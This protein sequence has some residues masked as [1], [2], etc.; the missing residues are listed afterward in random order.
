SCVHHHLPLCLM[1]LSRRCWCT[2]TS[3]SSCRHIISGLQKEL[4]TVLG[5]WASVSQIRSLEFL[6]KIEPL[7][8]ML[9]CGLNTTQLVSIG[10]DYWCTLCMLQIWRAGV[11]NGWQRL[12]SE[13][14]RRGKRGQGMYPHARCWT[15][16]LGHQIRTVRSSQALFWSGD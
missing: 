6:A 8:P 7:A 3:P 14:V 16:E 9:H 10:V 13:W 5:S 12:A 11:E 15:A 2:I 1:E 4:S